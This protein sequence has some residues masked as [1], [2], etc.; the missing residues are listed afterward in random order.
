MVFFVNDEKDR[1]FLEAM[2]RNLFGIRL[3][4]HLSERNDLVVQWA[5]SLRPRIVTNS[6]DDPELL[7]LM[8]KN[9]ADNINFLQMKQIN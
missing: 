9:T 4:I 8:I 3:F 1:S 6:G 7:A 5:H 2:E